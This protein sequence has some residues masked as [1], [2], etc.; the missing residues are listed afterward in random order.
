MKQPFLPFVCSLLIGAIIT[1]SSPNAIAQNAGVSEALKQQIQREFAEASPG[2]V[3]QDVVKTDVSGLYQILFKDVKPIYVMA[4]GRHFFTGDLMAV[5]KGKFVNVTRSEKDDL[6]KATLAELSKG[7][8]ITFHPKGAVKAKIYVFVDVDCGYCRKLHQEID[9]INA[10]GV[11]VNYLAYPRAGFGSMSYEKI[12]TAWCSENRSVAI[13]KLL[14]GE[15]L[16]KLTCAGDPVSK[17]YE[18]G[19]KLGITGTPA[20]MLESGKLIPGYI[21]ADGLAEELGL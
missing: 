2:L 15:Q 8:M 18:L 14:E 9:A 20:I 1:F 13:T 5:S 12:V 17:H 3:V 6:R 19:G 16:P 11:E 7:D 10:L 4:D 21:P